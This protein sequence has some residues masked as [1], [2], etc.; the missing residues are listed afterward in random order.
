[1]INVAEVDEN[2]VHAA[3]FD[4]KAKHVVDSLTAQKAVNESPEKKSEGYGSQQEAQGEPS[5]C[6]A[7]SD[8]VRVKAGAEHAYLMK[9]LNMQP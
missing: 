6:G 7:R 4:D 1:M 3:M 8:R 9:K 5:C 2:D